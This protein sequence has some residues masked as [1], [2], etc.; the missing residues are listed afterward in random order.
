MQKL[1]IFYTYIQLLYDASDI[2]STCE[3]IIIANATGNT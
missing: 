1:F 2:V 3:V